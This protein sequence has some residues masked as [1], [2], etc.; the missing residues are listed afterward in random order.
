MTLSGDRLNVACRLAAAFLALCMGGVDAKAGTSMAFRHR[1]AIHVY[2]GAAKGMN[3]IS[4]PDSSPYLDPNGLNTLCSHLN[5]S[6]NATIKQSDAQNGIVHPHKCGYLQPFMLKAQVG[7]LIL[8]TVA[9][10][11]MIVGSD[12][13]GQSYTFFNLGLGTGRNVFPVEYHATAVTPEDLCIQCGLSAEAT[14]TRYD[15]VTGY[16]QTH[17]CGNLA[18]FDLQRGEAVVILEPNGPKV[19]TPGHC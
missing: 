9:T 7:I 12:V 8:D 18:L 17:L 5:L 14:V 1:K 16:V 11:G 19:C 3:Y 4:L 2:D 13:E 15:A 6:A 10:E